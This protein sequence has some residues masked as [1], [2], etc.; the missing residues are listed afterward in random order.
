MR[1]RKTVI[2]AGLLIGLLQWTPAAS[3]A[4]YTF[5][6]GGLGV[7]SD[8]LDEFPTL[9][10]DLGGATTITTIA[11]DVAYESFA[12]SHRGDVVISIDTA[13]DFVDIYMDEYGAPFS[14]GIFRQAGSVNVNLPVLSGF[15][16]LTLWDYIP[17]D[18]M[19]VDALFEAGSFVRITFDPI[20]PTPIPEPSLPVL[21]AAGALAV[22]QKRRASRRAHDRV[23]AGA[24]RSAGAAHD[25]T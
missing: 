5:D 9:F 3:A 6:I 17:D 16:F 25:D 19:P 13:A 18:A 15:V 21:L 7:E 10:T 22:W 4:T 14:P 2:A 20:T 11:F 24:D 12:P 23:G 8:F 1:L